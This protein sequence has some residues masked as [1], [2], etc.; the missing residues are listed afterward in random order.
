MIIF[1][2]NSDADVVFTFDKPCKF[3]V[4]SQKDLT[5][6]KLYQK[7][8]WIELSSNFVGVPKV[9]TYDLRYGSAMLD[10]YAGGYL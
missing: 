3:T 1:V 7:S 5:N 9:V 2:V 8:F 10:Q 6:R 4:L